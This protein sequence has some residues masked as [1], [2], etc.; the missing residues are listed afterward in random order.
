MLIASGQVCAH[1]SIC[2]SETSPSVCHRPSPLRALFLPYAGGTLPK[3]GIGASAGAQTDVTRRASDLL[4][5]PW[6]ALLL[7][8]ADEVVGASAAAW[9]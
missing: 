9:G 5:G 8:F 1:I 4:H 2:S 7:G 6:R 3:S